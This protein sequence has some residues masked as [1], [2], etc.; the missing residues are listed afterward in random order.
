MRRTLNNQT[1][2]EAS[3]FDLL[4]EKTTFPSPDKCGNF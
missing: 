3:T 1:I 2:K 4:L